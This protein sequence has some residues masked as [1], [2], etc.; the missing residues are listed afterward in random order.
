M[1]H[2]GEIVVRGSQPEDGNRVNARRCGLFRQFDGSQSFI[3]SKHRAAEQADLLPRHDSNRASAQTGEVR[4]SL[5]RSVPGC[6]LAVE[7]RADALPPRGIVLQRSGFRLQPFLEV[8]RVRVERL[9][10][11]RVCEEVGEKTSRVRDLSEGQTLR[12]HRWIS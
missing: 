11:R 9:D 4:E 6:V 10:A 8:R 7:N 3:D 1:I 5:R 2:F 12:F